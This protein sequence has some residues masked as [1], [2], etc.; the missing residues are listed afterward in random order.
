MRALGLMSGTSL[1]GIDLAMIETD[2]ETIHA[3]GPTRTV[4]HSPETRA[5][6]RQASGEAMRWRQGTPV[7]DSVAAAADLIT[8]AHRRAIAGFL[9]EAG[10]V[11]VIGFHGQTVMHRPAEGLTWQVGDGGRLADLFGI[12]VVGQFRLADVAA[13]GQG[14]PLAPLYHRALARGLAGQRGPVAVLNLG[15]VGNVT[16]ISDDPAVGP[17]AFDTGPGNALID[18]WALH[19]TGVPIDRDG[20]LAGAGRVHGELVDLFRGHPF[21]DL[22]APKSLD[23][24]DFTGQPVRGLSAADGA[25]TLTAFTVEAAAAARRHFPEPATRVLVTGGGRLNPVLMAMLRARLGV[26]VE[27]VETVGWRGDSLEAEAFGFLAVRSLKGLPLSM[28]GTTGV[29]GPQT[30]GQLFRPRRMSR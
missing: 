21:F 24:D 14:A 13:G 3:L 26:P 17:V 29:P 10:P 12:E 28:P 15:G 22:P 8:E 27:P 7:P 25:A 2:G 20:A 23:R 11:E 5:A 6:C 16:W 9:A 1:D 18:D 4:A 30:G 19:H